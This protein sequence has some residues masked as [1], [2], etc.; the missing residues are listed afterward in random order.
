M[1]NISFEP[2]AWKDLGWWVKEDPKMLPRYM[3]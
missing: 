1:R 2:N 3:N